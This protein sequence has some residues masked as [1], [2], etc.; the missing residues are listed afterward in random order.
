MV[1]RDADWA[2]LLVGYESRHRPICVACGFAAGNGVLQLHRLVRR[3]EPRDH[4]FVWLC[5]RCRT[6]W[7]LHC[8]QHIAGSATTRRRHML[9]VIADHS[10]RARRYLRLRPSV[11]SHR[12]RAETL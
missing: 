6:A 8:G 1:E 10:P 3:A 9:R 11:P 5:S 7:F 4:H 2:E 12:R